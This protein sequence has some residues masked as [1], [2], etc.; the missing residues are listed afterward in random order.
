[1][2]AGDIGDTIA[3]AMQQQSQILTDIS[4]WDIQFIFAGC[5][6]VCVWRSQQKSQSQHLTPTKAKLSLGPGSLPSRSSLAV[7]CRNSINLSKTTTPTTIPSCPSSGCSRFWKEG[8]IHQPYLLESGFCW[9]WTASQS[10]PVQPWQWAWIVIS[11]F[12]K[13]QTYFN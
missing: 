12:S 2:P 5:V 10:L 8:K 11:P 7:L 6:C 4:F 9:S 3:S 1:M 13:P